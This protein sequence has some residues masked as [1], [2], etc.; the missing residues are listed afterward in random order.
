M[1]KRF[2]FRHVNEWTGALVLGVLAL[3]L[4]GIVF[5]AHSQGWFAVKYSLD[6][7]LPVEGALGLRRGDE[8]FVLGVSAGRI[9]GVRVDADGRMSA[10][11]KLRR[12]FERFI[13]VDSTASI[14]K[15]FGVAGDSFM[16]ITRGVG[17]PLPSSAPVLRCLA[18][19]DSFSRLEKMLADFRSELV[20]VVRKAGM[21]FDEWAEL[22]V[23]LRADGE[24]FQRI[25]KRL[26]NIAAG[27]EDG[28]GTA[29][30]L[31]TDN[32]LADEAQTLL[33]RANDAI[34]EMRGVLTNLDT[35]AANVQKGSVRLPELTGALAD[36][37]KD[38]PGLVQQTERSMREVERL[39]EAFQ[40]HWLIR[41]YVDHSDPAP[42]PGQVTPTLAGPKPG[43]ILR[44]P[45]DTK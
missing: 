7:L 23:A 6:V 32:T 5:S 27:V 44:S 19:D 9:E 38:L 42:P 45:R 43:K 22:G 30:R 36:E 10:R 18:P 11:V 37:A 4:A 34:G 16:E 8:V 17:S 2:Q 3:V 1:E 40:R 12:E 39:A 41:K 21:A 20:P 33:L 25:V 28:K 14:K 29:G 24:S 26:D 31:L 35:A 15:V 13:R